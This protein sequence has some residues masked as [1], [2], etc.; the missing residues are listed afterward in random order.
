MLM[1][2]VSKSYRLK[3]WLLIGQS[4]TKHF[5]EAGVHNDCGSATVLHFVCAGYL[6]FPDDSLIGPETCSF[7]RFASGDGSASH[8]VEFDGDAFEV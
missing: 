5:F 8:I 6:P 1:V 2:L 3:F 4:P 7:P